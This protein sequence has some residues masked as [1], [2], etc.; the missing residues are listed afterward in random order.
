MT[1]SVAICS[2][3]L[4]HDEDHWRE[5]RIIRKDGLLS[6]SDDDGKINNLEIVEESQMEITVIIRKEM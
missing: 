2:L 4:P 6:S 5:I 3:Q 1:R